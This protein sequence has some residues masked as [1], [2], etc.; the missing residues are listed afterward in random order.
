MPW[1]ETDREKY[2]VIRTRY[3]SDLSDA[4]FELIE[5]L[6]PARKSRGRKPT[7]AHAILNALFYMVRT[8]CP[9]RYLP[10]DFR[11]LRP[12][13]TASTRGATAVC[14]SRSSASW[15]WPFARRWGRRQRRQS[16]SLTASRS[17][18]PR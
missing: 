6:L 13:R 8:G 10:K 1:N 15:S 2:A 9:W 12:C 18:P 11:R 5:P 7:D 17:K 14:G 16:P 4:Q 3:A